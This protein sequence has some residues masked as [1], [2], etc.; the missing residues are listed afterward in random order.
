V[1]VLLSEPFLQR[2]K[3]CFAAALAGGA[4]GLLLLTDKGSSRFPGSSAPDADGN[5]HPEGHHAGEA[6]SKVREGT[7]RDEALIEAGMK[8][9]STIVMTTIAMAAR[10]VMPYALGVGAGRRIQLAVW[11]SP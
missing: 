1:L 3:S 7:P 2:S 4:I 8:R 6:P 11:R 5:R 9:A 10:A